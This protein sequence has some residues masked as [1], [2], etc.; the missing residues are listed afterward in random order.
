MC[1]SANIVRVATFEKLLS[2]IDASLFTQS[3]VR[4]PRAFAELYGSAIRAVK[5]ADLIGMGVH[6]LSIRSLLSHPGG[7]TSKV[8]GGAHCSTVRS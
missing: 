7:T 8:T 1:G 6:R 4:F 2:P 5:Q 3:T